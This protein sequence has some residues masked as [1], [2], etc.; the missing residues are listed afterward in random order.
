[1]KDI[2][3]ATFSA[4]INLTYF[5]QLHG[6]Y[7]A[8]YEG[9]EL[10][11]DFSLLAAFRFISTPSATSKDEC[12]STLNKAIKWGQRGTPFVMTLHSFQPSGNQTD[13]YLH[14]NIAAFLIARGEFSYYGPDDLYEGGTTPGWTPELDID[15]GIPEGYATVSNDGYLF[16]RK[17]TNFVITLDCSNFNASFI[18]SSANNKIISYKKLK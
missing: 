5:L 12:V 3:G 15:Y 14:Q 1:M 6:K 8:V 2:Q 4:L 9:L 11:P 7:S 10:D 16:T 13:I 18:P 17:W